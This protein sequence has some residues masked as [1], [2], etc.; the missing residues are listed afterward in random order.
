MDS[1]LLSLVTSFSPDEAAERMKNMLL[2]QQTHVSE[3]NKTRVL[4]K[5]LVSLSNSDDYDDVTENNEVTYDDI[6][7]DI[8]LSNDDNKQISVSS[9]S[10]SV[11]RNF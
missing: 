11:I 6:A 9:P 8:E 1:S 2:K 7:E 5:E 4:G 10:L 3:V